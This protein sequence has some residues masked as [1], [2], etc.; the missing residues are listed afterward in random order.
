MRKRS[1]GRKIH[2]THNKVRVVYMMIE[3]TSTF[4]L[5]LLWGSTLPPLT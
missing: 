3:G 1:A 4:A 2:A 5:M